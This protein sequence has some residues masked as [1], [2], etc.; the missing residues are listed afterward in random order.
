MADGDYYASYADFQ[1]I[2]MNSGLAVSGNTLFDE[3]A[4]EKTLKITQARIHLK[5]KLETLTSLT[6]VVYVEILKGI[7][8]HL[9]TQ[10]ALAARTL[11]EQNLSSNEILTT[12][13]TLSPN[14]TNQ[15]LDELRDIERAVNGLA[16][17]NYDIRTGQ[18]I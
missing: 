8:I 6:H 12:W 4:T 17:K 7:Q 2:M 14:F 15:Q 3:N 16:I 13:W 9:L 5:L 1:H 10:M 18:S 11:Q